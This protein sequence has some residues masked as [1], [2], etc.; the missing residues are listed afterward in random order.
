M[1]KVLLD[2]DILSEVLKA[3]DLLV[4]RNAKEYLGAFGRLTVSAITVA[5]IVKGFQKIQ[6]E[7]RLR[8][9]DAFLN[10]N[11]VLTLGYEE[12][13]LAGRISG[14][15]ER[16]GFPIGHFDPFIAAIAVVHQLPLVTGNTRHFLRVCKLG[17]ALELQNWRNPH[18]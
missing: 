4:Q 17:Y 13:T 1:K 18:G 6:D 11:E 7:R 9:F 12:A 14:D 8:L 15:L 3:K 16:A 2:T 5:E 10:E